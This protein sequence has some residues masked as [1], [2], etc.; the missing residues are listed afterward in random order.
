MM[1]HESKQSGSNTISFTVC[2]ATQEGDNG[3]QEKLHIRKEWNWSKRVL[4]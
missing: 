2:G 4:T 3:D 1:S